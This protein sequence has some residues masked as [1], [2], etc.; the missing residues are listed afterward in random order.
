MRKSNSKAELPTEGPMTIQDTEEA[1]VPGIGHRVLDGID[2]LFPSA[3]GEGWFG[4]FQS[5]LVQ[6]LWGTAF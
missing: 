4:V 3:R 6:S 5:E 1:A 2:S